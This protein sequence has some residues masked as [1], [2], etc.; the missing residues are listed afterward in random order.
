MAN[1][2]TGIGVSA[3]ICLSEGVMYL[4]TMQNGQPMFV[5]YKIRPF[6]REPENKQTSEEIVQNPKLDEYINRLEALEKE[7][8]ELKQKTGYNLNELIQ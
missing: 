4:K 7:I 2:P 3:A 1:V 8:N 5:G 6:D